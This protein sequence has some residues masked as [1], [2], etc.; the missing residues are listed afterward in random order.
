MDRQL[1]FNTSR[2]VSANTKLV[3]SVTGTCAIGDSALLVFTRRGIESKSGS[4][5]MLTGASVQTMVL[6][7]QE[8]KARIQGISEHTGPPNHRCRVGTRVAGLQPAMRRESASQGARNANGDSVEAND[9][10][11]SPF[12]EKYEQTTTVQQEMSVVSCRFRL[13]DRSCTFYKS[14]AK[15]ARSERSTDATHSF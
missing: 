12:S 3:A 15:G 4:T 13:L 2:P 7:L 10:R 14:S 1:C 6:V 8:G 5:V 9:S 11:V